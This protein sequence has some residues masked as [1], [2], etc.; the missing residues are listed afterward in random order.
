MKIEPFKFYYWKHVLKDKKKMIVKED[1][2]FI[3][4]VGSSSSDGI[5]SCDGIEIRPINSSYRISVS[6]T[7]DY[8]N[9]GTYLVREM[10]FSDLTNEEKKDFFVV[11]FKNK[12]IL[13][14]LINIFDA[15]KTLRKK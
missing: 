14:E 4:H 15:I 13:N 3:V 7:Y 9:D 12:K 11:I 6:Y 8:I 2:C 10:K 5:I 1:L